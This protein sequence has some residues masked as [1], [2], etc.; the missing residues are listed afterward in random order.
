ML[1]L[2][3]VPK[4]LI[5]HIGTIQRNAIR[6]WTLLRPSCEIL[7]FGNDT[8]IQDVAAEFGVQNVAEIAR[9]EFGTPLLSDVFEKA[10]QVA[11]HRLLC[12]VNAD[13]VLFDD[14][15]AVTS[16]IPKRRFLMIGRRTDLDLR[17]PWDFEHPEWRSR[18]QA[19]V[20]VHGKLHAHTGV[21]YYVFPS[22]LWGVIPPFA[23]GRTIYDNWLIWRARSLGV[24]VIDASRVVMCIHQ[25]HARTYTSLGVKAPDAGNDLTTSAEAARNRA[26]AGGRHHVFTLRNA[27][28]IMTSRGLLPA[29]APQ[30]LW[31]RTVPTLRR[32]RDAL[33]TA[34]ARV[35]L[36]DS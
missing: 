13:I 15:L 27:N 11:Q 30:Y 31:G 28:W 17:V 14:L 32:A 21:D 16:R 19:E 36:R 6:S 33:R 5:G 22:G 4:P 29:V 24:P 12:Y 35:K 9:N 25:D 10:Q 18:L 34:L 3:T 23:I 2:F 20:E 7:L 26:L 8:G 1:T